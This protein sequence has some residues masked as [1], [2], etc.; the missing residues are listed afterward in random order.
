MTLKENL[1]KK[2]NLWHLAAVGIF[3]LIASVY[4][5]P[6]LSGFQVKQGDV[7]NWAGAAQEIADYRE[8]G[9]QIGWTNSMFSGMPATQISMVY[10]G[11]AIPDFFRKVLTLGLPTP[12]SLLFVYFISFYILAIAFRAKPIVAIVASIAYGLSSYFII[13]IEAGH[14]TKAVAVGY[15]P[16]LIAGFIFAYRWKNWVLGVAL[17]ALFMTFQLSAN[18]L[19]ITYY[20]IFVLVALGGV[21]LFR[22]I[23]MENGISRFLKIS[24]GMI[25]AYGIGIMVNYGNIKGTAE[26]TDATTRG[27]TEL[28]IKA[29][30]SEN[31]DIKTSGLDRDYITAWSYGK[32]ETFTFIVPNY[33]G[34][35]TGRIGENKA[36]ES[37]LKQADSMFRNDIKNSNQYWG[38]Q[39]FTSGPVY[40]GVIVVLLALLSLAY[41]KE[42]SR[43]P[44]FAV[45]LLVV[46]LSWG[47]NLMGFTDLFL[48]IMPGYNK[49]RAVTIILVIAELCV[50]LLALF[51]LQKLYQ[52]KEEIAKNLKPFLFISGG[53][54]FM[55]LILI[56]A[57]GMFNTFLSEQETAMLEQV[58][59]AQIEMYQQFFTEIENVRIS[60]FRRD[61]GR[62]VLFLILGAGVIF[63]YLKNAFNKTVLAAILGVLILSDLIL[64]DS[65]YLGTEKT[66]KRFEQWVEAYKQKYPYTAGEAEQQILAFEMEENPALYQKIDSAINATNAQL[67]GKEI[68]AA[69]KMRIISWVTFRTLNRYTNFRVFEEGNAFNSSY[70]SYFNKSIGGYHGA[71]L[72]RYQDL[73]EFHLSKNNPSVMDMLNA[74]YRLQPK[75]DQNG[76]L[77]GSMLTGKNDNAMGNAWLSKGIQFVK[78]ADEEIMAL[79][80]A[81]TYRIQPFGNH[82]LMVNG[83][84][85]TI[86]IVEATDLIDIL[87]SG[88]P[89]STGVARVDTIPVEVPYQAVTA[90]LPIAY[91][92]TAQGATW[93]YVMNV[94]STKM[95]LIGVTPEGKSGWQPAL[96]TV[97]DERYKPNVTQE[98]YSGEG[99]VAMTSY[100][101]D[102]LTYSFSSPEKQLVVFSEIYYPVGWKAYVDGVET[103]ISCVNYV[104]RAVEVPAGDHKIELVY[105]LD[106][107]QS[108]ATFAWIGSILILVLLG[109]GV[110]MQTKMKDSSGTEETL[111]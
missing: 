78:S 57:P 106:S 33:K 85:D 109:A 64:V 29:D 49:F 81:N 84:V 19:Q 40:L 74:K 47:K 28:T 23:K 41:N 102:M 8:S 56:A 83:V 88:A 107:Y 71:K 16:L 38:D 43:W 104:L 65:R 20:L 17:S 77:T 46:M 98:K 26:Y 39:P 5:H 60:I 22:H 45:T 52:A 3:I 59:P 21:E 58:D 94:D 80:A 90:E 42:A 37:A 12:I 54:I 61:V 11:R 105:K 44:L 18:H 91:V 6:A 100:H 14:I 34:G 7:K 86:G 13:I 76:E 108:S 25:V 82:R 30:G 99:T 62:S 4:F 51:F 69:E 1:L 110:Y 2:S 97:V 87:F 55:L 9:E 72:G 70:V 48:D 36:N 96:T 67:S 66:G 24:A 32:A 111:A 27:G 10:E 68:E 93:D 92:L 75:Y 101:P 63:A 31:T 95:P 103:P 73:I 35:E 53:L 89:D 79:N 50:P 15:A